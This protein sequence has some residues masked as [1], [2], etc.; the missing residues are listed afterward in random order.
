MKIYHKN[1][2]MFIEFED[3]LEKESWMRLFRKCMDLKKG[4]TEV[5]KVISMKEYIEKFKKE[6]IK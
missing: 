6:Q 5:S 3:L 1:K 2:L 4:D